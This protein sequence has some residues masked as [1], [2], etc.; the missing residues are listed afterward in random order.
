MNRGQ[1]R[2]RRL[3]D[4]RQRDLQD[5]RA[6][7]WRYRPSYRGHP[8]LRP[9]ERVLQALPDGVWSYQYDP[10]P[11]VVHRLPVLLKTPPLLARYAQGASSTVYPSSTPSRTYQRNVGALRASLPLRDTPCRTRAERRR[12]LFMIGIA[13][14]G[15][16]RSP[17]PY[18]RTA[19]SEF[20]CR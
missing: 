7:E 11:V 19:Q 10:R 20:S 8:V 17:G 14:L 6:S 5:F 3:S 4:Y 18:H 15:K 9:Q 12:T 13:G 2:R 16:K 1:N